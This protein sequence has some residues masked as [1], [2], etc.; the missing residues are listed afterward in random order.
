MDAVAVFLLVED[1]EDDVFIFRRAYKQAKLAHPLYVVTDGSEATDYLM[2]TGKYRDRSEFPM[3]DVVFLDLKLPL[4]SGL[5][6]L[7]WIRSRPELAKLPV[8]VLTSS[9][10]S[11]DISRAQ[12]LGAH[13]YIVK[14]P[15]AETLLQIVQLLRS[16]RTGD[17]A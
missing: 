7:E 17:E 16:Q 8:V 1:N 13:S 12:E 5:E 10:E 6:V 11:R 14:P 9:A 3:P 4:R 15:K 2:G